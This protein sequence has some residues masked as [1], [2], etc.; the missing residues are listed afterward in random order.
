MLTA[1]ELRSKFSYISDIASLTDNQLLAVQ[2]HILRLNSN[3]QEFHIRMEDALW[4][5]LKQPYYS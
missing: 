5:E 2:Q 3:A 4:I 1:S